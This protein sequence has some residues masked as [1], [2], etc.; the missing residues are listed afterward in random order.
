MLIG[1]A[2]RKKGRAAVLM[3]MLIPAMMLASCAESG[4]VIESLSCAGWKPIYMS[5]NDSLTPETE[6]AIIAHNEYGAA[7]GCWDSGE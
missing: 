1:K 5:T 2:R 3:W 7:E 4:L 6:K